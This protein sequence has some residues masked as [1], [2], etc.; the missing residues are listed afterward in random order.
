VL[1]ITATNS[2]FT[3]FKIND[4]PNGH[5]TMTKC[6]KAVLEKITM[7]SVSKNNNFAYNTDAWGC[8]YSK[9]LIFRDSVVT[10]GDDCAAINGGMSIY[11]L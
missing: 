4:A 9:N 10:N 2:L 1:R 7:H 5:I 8:A 11:R 6:E 3:N